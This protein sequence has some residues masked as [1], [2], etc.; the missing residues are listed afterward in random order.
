MSASAGMSTLAGISCASPTIIEKLIQNARQRP[1]QNSTARRISQF[2]IHLTPQIITVAPEVKQEVNPMRADQMAAEIIEE[3]VKN[4][5]IKQRIEAINDLCSK[6]IVMDMKSESDFLKL[7]AKNLGIKLE[8]KLESNTLFRMDIFTQMMSCLTTE[9]DFLRLHTSFGFMG[10][11]EQKRGELNT[12][13]NSLYGRIRIVNDTVMR[14]SKESWCYILHDDNVLIEFLNRESVK[15]SQIGQKMAKEFESLISGKV[16]YSDDHKTDLCI[17]E[18]ERIIK[19]SSIEN[20]ILSTKTLHERWGIA[21]IMNETAF[22]KLVVKNLGIAFKNNT[23]EIPMDRFQKQMELGKSNVAFLRKYLLEGS[24]GNYELMRTMITERLDNSEKALNMINEEI[25]SLSYI[26]TDRYVLDDGS[27]VSFKLRETKKESQ[28]PKEVPKETPIEEL[29]KN[30]LAI[31]D[32]INVVNT[33][34]DRWLRPQEVYDDTSECLKL[35]MKNM[36]ITPENGTKTT[37][38]SIKRFRKFIVGI[39]DELVLLHKYLIITKES[40]GPHEHKRSEIINKLKAL[41]DRMFS[42]DDTIIGL[43]EG[44]KRITFMDGSM[45]LEFVEKLIPSEEP[46]FL[47][48]AAEEEFEK[49]ESTTAYYDQLLNE[50]YEYALAKS[51]FTKPVSVI[52]F[53]QFQDMKFRENLQG[54]LKEFKFGTEILKGLQGPAYFSGSMVVRSILGKNWHSDLDMYITEKDLPEMIQ[55]LRNL[56]YFYNGT[57]ANYGKMDVHGFGIY[58]GKKYIGKD[59]NGNDREYDEYITIDLVVVKSPSAYSSDKVM[60][61]K[62]F[63]SFD[64]DICATRY[65]AQNDKFIFKNRNLAVKGITHYKPTNEYL[66][67]VDMSEEKKK[68]F[69]FEHNRHRINKYE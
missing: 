46:N 53:N 68:D 20:R 11:Y 17:K 31:E 64:M 12:L 41:R 47:L 15:E 62:F 63:D 6:W 16:I 24:L 49:T 65:D 67:D 61:D 52:D 2:G 14:L 5:S 58:T 29:I 50:Y 57:G 44:C 69:I 27:V 23:A 7:A 10:S 28:K 21:N 8:S 36:G 51:Q 26:Y 1:D 4:M 54:H 42:I 33:L 60:M 66:S 38:F 59:I 32:R 40:L 3:N 22:I 43:S 19:N 13:V 55:R 30:G 18:A 34:C 25:T 37:K 39:M 56:G 35:V 48:S 45:E 9:I